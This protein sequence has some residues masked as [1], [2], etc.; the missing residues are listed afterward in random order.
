MLGAY[1]GRESDLLPPHADNPEGYWEHS[2]I[3]A[4]HE[5]LLNELSTNWYST[6]PLPVTWWL[7]TL[8]NE[9]KSRL[10]ELV[11]REFSGHSFWAWKDPRTCL[12]LPIW[13]DVFDEMGV[14]LQFIIVTRNPLDVSK[15]LFR[16]DGMPRSQALWLWSHYVLS[17][18]HHTSGRSRTIVNYDG[19]LDDAPGVLRRI[20]TELILPWPDNDSLLREQLSKHMKPT[21]RHA[22]SGETE[23][24]TDRLVPGLVKSALQ[25]CMRADGSTELLH[26]DDFSTDVEALVHRYD[27]EYKPSDEMN[28]DRPRLQVFW[29]SPQGYSEVNS[30]TT[31][32]HNFQEFNHYDL[33]MPSN[34]SFPLRIDPVNVPAVIE[35]KSIGVFPEDGISSHTPIRRW[36]PID[37]VKDISI[38]H[39]LHLI[40]ISGDNLILLSTGYDP[41]LFLAGIPDAHGTVNGFRVGIEMRVNTSITPSVSKLLEGALVDLDSVRAELTRQREELVAINGE[42][43]AKQ[44][45]LVGINEQ[46][47]AQQ[48]RL[49]TQLSDAEDKR[50]ELT[51]RHLQTIAELHSQLDSAREQLDLR[52][53]QI[54]NY[55]VRVA[56]N[57]IRFTTYEEQIANYQARVIEDEI[58]VSRYEAQVADFQAKILEYEKR[59]K[60]YE[61]QVANVQAKVEGYEASLDQSRDLVRDHQ[62]LL[63]IRE[64]EIRELRTWLD[65]TESEFLVVQS[66]LTTERMRMY[67]ILNSVSW[68]VTE[69]LRRIN[70]VLR[71]R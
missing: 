66:E 11:D 51:E 43:M 30:A 50:A 58:R 54:V 65:A 29:M 60:I 35:I 69:P 9:Y 52:N 49:I 20:A 21:L 23:V 27:D 40:K 64:N 39:D 56:E 5:Q 4:F 67:A 7:S 24:F 8:A 46:A 16:R 61:V 57:E 45:E 2:K 1:L 19:L 71:R 53:D 31:S 13:Q 25:L 3:V 34:A 38:G 42:T 32:I 17:A 22:M 68:K 48:A 62:A 15:S 26:S 63:S 55:R 14:D 47:L 10:R 6:R 18:L 28:F 33:Y 12:L 44:E 41:Q 70:K 59:M 37:A 36:S